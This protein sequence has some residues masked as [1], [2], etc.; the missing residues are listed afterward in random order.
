[1]EL[2]L[3]TTD[4]IEGRRIVE[5]FGLVVGNAIM[6]NPAG[7][8]PMRGCDMI[9]DDPKG[10]IPG[11]DRSYSGS[12]ISITSLRDAGVPDIET[13]TDAM[14]EAREDA[15]NCMGEIA[16]GMGANA[17]IGLR[18]GSIAVTMDATEFV[19]YGT[20]VLVDDV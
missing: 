11:V 13:Y 1:M 16:L 17:V 12:G 8:D 3:V 20:A 14:T 18:L 10:S 5:T 9:D 2:T 7:Y 19:A 4:R 15:L 6:A